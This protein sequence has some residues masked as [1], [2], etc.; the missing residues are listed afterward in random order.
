[1]PDYSKTIMY[2]I[3]CK[4]ENVEEEYIGSTTNFKERLKCHKIRCCNE[5]GKCYNLNIYQF[6]RSHGGWDNWLMLELEKF[7]CDDKREAEYRE[8]E[9][10]VE[11]KAQLNAKKAFRTEEQLKEYDKERNKK[12]REENKEKVK[13][14]DKIYYEKNKEKLKEQ[15]KKWVE[16]NREK[17]KGYKKKYEEKKKAEKLLNNSYEPAESNTK[18]S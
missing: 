9:I 1:M 11:R 13:E 6:I 16:K 2:V 14:Q 12:Y 4:D 3:K 15:M 8:E 10:R 18:P 7:P 17:S 5:N